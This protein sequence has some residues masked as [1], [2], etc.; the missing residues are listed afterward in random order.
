MSEMAKITF[1]ALFDS[2]EPHLSPSTT[3]IG[4]ETQEEYLWLKTSKILYLYYLKGIF[5]KK[6]LRS[7]IFARIELFGV[8]FHL[9][10]GKEG[11]KMTENLFSESD[12]ASKICHQL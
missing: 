12:T 8:H 4:T 9:F 6:N 10:W 1:F 5:F 3:E 7:S 2:L 11:Q